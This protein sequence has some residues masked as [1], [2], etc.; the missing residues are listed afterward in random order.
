MY[1]RTNKSQSCEKLPF[2]C[3]CAV[4]HIGVMAIVPINDHQQAVIHLDIPLQDIHH[5]VHLQVLVN[6][7]VVP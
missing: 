5:Q 6:L 1:F 4:L 2:C 3:Y 7:S